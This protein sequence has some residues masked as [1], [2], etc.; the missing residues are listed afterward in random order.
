M[1]KTAWFDR[2]FTFGFSEGMLPFFLERLEGSIVRIEAKLKG[3]GEDLLSLQADSKWSIKE[4]V[5]HLAD[6]NGITTKRIE[7]IMTGV[8]PMSR[9]DLQ[10]QRDYNKLSAKEVL[11]YFKEVR[12]KNLERLAG[13]SDVELKKSS[14]H[15]RLN[16]QMNAVDLAY[17]DAEHD[18]H[19][20]VRINEIKAALVKF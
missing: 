16:V 5:G 13:L 3:L 12:T 4:N 7:E 6:A 17:F 1:T 20:M 8:S 18:D 10:T 15:P 11:S 19:H 9:A 2:Q 14:L